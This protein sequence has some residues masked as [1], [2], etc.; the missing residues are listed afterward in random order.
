MAGR[1][2]QPP[3]SAD[4]QF[5]MDKYKEAV[6]HRADLLM[7]VHVLKDEIK[8]LKMLYGLP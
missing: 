2:A 5:W 3:R 8:C 6:K 1:V 7:E 4:V